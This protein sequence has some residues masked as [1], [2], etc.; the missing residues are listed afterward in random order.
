MPE[1]CYNIKLQFSVK[2]RKNIIKIA[3]MFYFKL[4]KVNKSNMLYRKNALENAFLRKYEIFL[5][6][7]FNNFFLKCITFIHLFFNLKK[8]SLLKIIFVYKPFLYFLF[9][10]EKR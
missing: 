1:N 10:T 6:F 4:I 2:I 5:S 8:S 9:S 3:L 7:L